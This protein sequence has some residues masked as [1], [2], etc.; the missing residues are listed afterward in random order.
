LEGEK[1]P[2][3]VPTHDHIAHQILV[4]HGGS[5]GVWRKKGR[6]GGTEGRRKGGREGE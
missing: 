2:M 3:L 5:G 4:R 6:E 1:F